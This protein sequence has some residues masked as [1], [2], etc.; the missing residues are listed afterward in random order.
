[1]R[2]GKVEKKKIFRRHDVTQTYA[3]KYFDDKNVE[4]D[5]GSLNECLLLGRIK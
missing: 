3:E 2:D 5:V 1:M 4:N